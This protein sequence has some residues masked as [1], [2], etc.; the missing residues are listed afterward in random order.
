MKL[1]RIDFF[2]QL[3]AKWEV[4]DGSMNYDPLDEN[5]CGHN[6]AKKAN[7]AKCI[8]DEKYANIMCPFHGR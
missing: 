3:S 5:Y 2:R 6:L 8:C 1:P 7:K 4:Y